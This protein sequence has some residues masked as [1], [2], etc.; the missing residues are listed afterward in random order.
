MT[1]SAKAVATAASTALPPRA[2]IAWPA[3]VASGCE[4]TTIPLAPRTG[5]RLAAFRL[6]ERVEAALLVVQ[7]GDR[8]LVGLAWVGI[9]HGAVH[10]QQQP[11]AHAL[12][13]L[14]AVTA[15]HLP[16]H[17]RHAERSQHGAQEQRV[18][19]HVP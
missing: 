6:G 5:A 19:P 12:D 15:A 1:A 11:G 2:S 10:G 4:L 14:Q 17:Q 13:H 7:C 18:A 8:E 16:Q 3:R 9:A